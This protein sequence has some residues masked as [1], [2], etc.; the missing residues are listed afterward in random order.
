M[1]DFINYSEMRFIRS[2]SKG[3]RYIYF[4]TSGGIVRI[5]N[6]TKR[7]D[8]PYTYCSGLFS[9]NIY[10][11]LYDPNTNIL[12]ALSDK[13]VSTFSEGNRWW[14]N[15]R[16]SLNINSDNTINTFFGI[17]DNYI[18]IK[19]NNRFYKSG[20]F[21]PNFFISSQNEANSDNVKWKNAE[22]DKN[23]PFFKSTS[24]YTYF[25]DGRIQD[26][27][28]RFFPFTDYTEDR[29]NNML[30]IGTAGA[31][32][33]AGDLI[34][35]DLSIRTLGPAGS[36]VRGLFKDGGTFWM[37]GYNKTPYNGI[38]KWNVSE[39]KWEY[40]ETLK[41]TR[42][43]S[44]NINYING[45][46]QYIFFATDDG[47]MVYEKSNK[48]WRSFT[49][50]NNLAVNQVNHVEIFNN[51][52]WIST[53][54]GLAVM[55]LPGF[56]IS[57]IDVEPIEDFHIYATSA[58]SRFVWC[59]TEL[60]I[61][62]YN[63]LEDKWLYVEGA[64]GILQRYNKAICR[65]GDEMWFVSDNG[66]QMYNMKTDEW[67]GYPDKMYFQN[68]DFNYISASDNILWFAADQGLIK[69]DRKNDFWKL[70]TMADGLPSNII[71]Y[72]LP[73]GDFIWL[74]TNEGLVRFY[75][76]NPKHRH[77]Y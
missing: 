44:S 20:K 6:F 69:Y 32:I 72:I 41:N 74:A 61:Y 46:E 1:D 64:P 57:K 39:N 71:T 68:I 31:G 36:S 15:A 33:A 54:I 75:W 60:G 5:D 66:I 2:V 58:D 43:R 18:W 53:D 17:G 37:G 7:F 23:F 3:N 67:T 16:L 65:N 55:T 70:Y 38:T 51:E 8:Y 42:I 52:V 10:A 62:R 25:Q 27:Y 45:N 19:T 40:F 63:R 4:G 59:A 48:R 14:N 56:L 11:T 76:N 34:M 13:A 30:W 47:L 50:Y 21:S 24:E 73:D 22:S 9:D 77:I 12:W 28:L 35:Q 29:M 49:T 26:N